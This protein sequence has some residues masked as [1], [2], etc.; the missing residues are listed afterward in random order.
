MFFVEWEQC[1]ASRAT[2]GES[3]GERGHD[4]I[5]EMDVQACVDG[6]RGLH[7]AG[8]LVGALLGEGRECHGR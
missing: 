1:K 3:A 2:P 6:R 8:S 7:R 5:V 4:N